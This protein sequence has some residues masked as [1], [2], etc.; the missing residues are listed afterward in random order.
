MNNDTNNENSNENMNR[1][2]TVNVP[3]QASSSKKRKPLLKNTMSPAEYKKHVDAL[4]KARIEAK[5]ERERLGLVNKSKPASQRQRTVK[6]VQSKAEKKN[7]SPKFSSGTGIYSSNSTRKIRRFQQLRK[8]RLMAS[9]K[10]YM[11]SLKANK[12]QRSQ[13]A[14]KYSAAREQGVQKEQQKK[15]QKA[16]SKKSVDELISMFGKAGLN[17]GPKKQRNNGGPENEN[18]NMNNNN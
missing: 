15:Q 7:N 6:K 11:N 16:Q 13:R 12:S 3:S 9:R 8:S 4:I 17:G 2:H 14:S 1:G 5:R 18:E 10:K